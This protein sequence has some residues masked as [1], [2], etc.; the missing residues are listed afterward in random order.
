M[1]ASAV[2]SQIKE[3]D[4][5]H[6]SIDHSRRLSERKS[7][8]KNKMKK[9]TSFEKPKIKSSPTQTTKFY[10]S[11]WE[12]MREMCCCF[13]RRKILNKRMKSSKKQNSLSIL[14]LML[15]T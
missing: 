11:F 14:L 3:G 5:I 13:K 12:Y 6:S 1:A 15:E 9:L 4:L 8:F 2:S 10:I 7:F